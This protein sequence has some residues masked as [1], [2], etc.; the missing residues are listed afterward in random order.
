M[1]VKFICFRSFLLERLATRHSELTSAANSCKIA[2]RLRLMEV[3][4]LQNNFAAAK[5]LLSGLD[6]VM[7]YEEFSTY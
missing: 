7:R 6:E 3:A 2:M 5:K 1:F 4:S